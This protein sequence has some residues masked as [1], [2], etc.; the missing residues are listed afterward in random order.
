MRLSFTSSVTAHGHA[1]VL[2]PFSRL[3]NR[4]GGRL[5]GQQP[6]IADRAPPGSAR[7]AAS[8]PTSLFPT[9]GGRVHAHLH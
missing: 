7:R 9:S 8:S 6:D 4:P 3:L 1:V 2:L 5:V